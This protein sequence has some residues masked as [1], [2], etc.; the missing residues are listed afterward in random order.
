MRL[1]SK[2]RVTLACGDYDRTR[3][4]ADGT[5]QVEGVELNYIPL[6][7][8]ETFWRME[9]FEEFDASEMSFGAYTVHRGHGESRFIALPIFP[10]RAFRHNAIYVHSGAG[11]ERPEDLKGRRIGVPE[12]NVTAAVWM[13][14]ML[15][16][17]YGVSPSDLHWYQGGLHDPGR[18]EKVMG[19]LPPG[20]SL[21]PLAEGKTL[22]DMLDSGELD[23]LMVP[24]MPRAFVEGSP[25][26]RRLFPDYRAVEQDYFRRTGLFP[27][28]HAIV[29]RTAVF[30]ANRWLAESL[31]KAFVRAKD[32]CANAMTLNTAALPYMLPWMMDEME[33][34][35]RIMGKDYWP[36]GLEANR[37]PLTTFGHY[38]VEQGLTS[39]ALPLESLF[40]APTLEEFKV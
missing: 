32:A 1:M 5:V 13:R 8:E 34:T 36:Y 19:T 39:Q 23:A 20:V 29:L 30:E 18:R 11:I 12:Y 35:R 33:E 31:F 26:V 17:E 27:I 2:L 21:E 4:L 28:M 9:H 10:S 6:G 7:P 14:G 37:L 16:H 3:A 40:A 22:N 24:R 38:A 25:N 15:Q